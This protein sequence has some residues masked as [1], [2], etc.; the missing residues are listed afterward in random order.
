MTA[1]E[2]KIIME[3]LA[4]LGDASANAFIVYLIFEFL[5][6]LIWAAATLGV[7]CVIGKTIR[8]VCTASEREEELKITR[9][10]AKDSGMQLLSQY[11]QRYEG[12]IKYGSPS[13]YQVQ[14]LKTLMDKHMPPAPAPEKKP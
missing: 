12:E 6:S 14:R 13:E 10:W 3:T 1:D 11:V 7:A 5:P 9:M 4:Q 8:H 2:L